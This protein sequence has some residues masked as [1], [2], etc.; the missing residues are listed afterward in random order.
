MVLE[1]YTFIEAFYMT[2]ITIST[3]GYR[4]V[5]P[6][7]NAGMIFT[8]VLILT[9]IGTF[10]YAISAI[11]TYFV[12]G[13]YRNRFKAAKV[14]KEIEKYENHVIV[15]G[16]GRVGQMAASQLE[17][18][19][20]QVVV[21]EMDEGKIDLINET[22]PY[23]CIHGN[24]T[25]DELLQRAGIDKAQALIT[26]LPDDAANLYV[27][28]TAKELN[29]RLTLISRASKS[30]S[31]KKLR[32]AGADNVIMPDSV[33][34]AHMASLVVTPDVI[35]FID[36]IRIQ[37]E[38]EINLEE[39]AFTDLPPDFQYQTLGELDVRNRIGVNIIGFKTTDGQ[40]IINPGSETR[41]VPN[42]KLFV[43]GNPKQIKLLNRIFGIQAT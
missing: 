27:V 21:I 28:L 25:Q 26:T 15:C 4:E 7:S 19:D 12:A 32:I 9:S 30:E 31:V 41:I 2:M 5:H 29:N 40:Y 33:G 10:T 42:S 36:H 8:A 22:K 39:V 13:E 1:D 43:L 11:T 38:G 35:D 23:W 34:G 16:F 18:H 24:A 20:Q 17:S 14:K 3:V 37:G 6:L